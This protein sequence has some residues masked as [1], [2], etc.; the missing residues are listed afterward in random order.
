MVI[1]DDRHMAFPEEQIAAAQGGI[2][3]DVL[4]SRLLQIAVAGQGN[5]CGRKGQLHKA[6]AIQARAGVAAPV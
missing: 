5:A 3:G 1:D 4:P 2:G 6:R